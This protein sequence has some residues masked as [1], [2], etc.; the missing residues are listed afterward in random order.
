MKIAASPEVDLLLCCARLA[1]EPERRERVRGL[2]AAPLDWVRFM[3]LASFHGLLPLVHR[4]LDAIASMSV[5]RSVRVELWGRHEATAR[6]NGARTRELLRIL[7]GLDSQGIAAIP[8]KGPALAAS[9]Y[10]DVALREFGD[11]DIVVRARDVMHAKAHLEAQ[12]YV[13]AYP[14]A[15]AIEAAFLRSSAQYHLVL[16]NKE[17]DTMVEL[18]WK[19][20]PDFPVESLDDEG[21]WAQLGTVEL[22]GGKARAF[23]T[24][25]LM[26]ILCLH[27]SKHR[28]SSLGWLVDVAELIRQNPE[29]DWRW[30][31]DKAASM[32]CDRRLALGLRLAHSLLEAPISE[33]VR[34][35]IAKRPEVESLA[36]AIADRLFGP[37]GDEPTAFELL[38]L[39]LRLYGS[40]RQRVTHCLN[41]IWAP[42]L[43]EWSQWPLPRPLFFLYPPL[44]LARLTAKHL[45]LALRARTKR[46]LEP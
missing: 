27:G 19:T 12:A 17:R 39:N 40:T 33:P 4:H 18:H 45:A 31:F 14:L 9:V 46:V 42:S 11:L 32:R 21:W 5:P 36:G 43:V 2:L 30:I 34:A 38:R 8:Y 13:C 7:E 22:E 23:T 6:R 41:T 15:P 26:L 37:D 3:E 10:G 20:D 35:W 44:R 29:L 28:W 16:L 1:L 24:P 25:E